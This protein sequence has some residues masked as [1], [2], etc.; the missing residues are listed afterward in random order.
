MT[1]IPERL[2]EQL[3]DRMER[4]RFLRR[5]S[6][7]I[8]GMV[9]T[10]AAGGG[11]QAL[12]APSA[13]ANDCSARSSKRGPGCHS[14]FGHGPCGPSPCCSHYGSSKCNCESTAGS[15]KRKGANKGYC[16]GDGFYYKG[17]NCWSCA[18]GHNGDCVTIVTCCDC[19]IN[20]SKRSVCG[21]HLGYYANRCISWY[22]TTHC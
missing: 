15:C 9:A 7:I 2:A 13:F 17:T 6:K 5:S 19:G 14:F 20:P 22:A 11:V 4:R 1:E 16:E 8:F 10:L 3:A 21:A 18:Y 12:T